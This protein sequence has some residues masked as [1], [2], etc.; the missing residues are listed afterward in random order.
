MAAIKTKDGAEFI[1]RADLNSLGE[2][3][4]IYG[5]VSAASVKLSAVAELLRIAAVLI[6]E[7]YYYINSPERITPASLG[8][9]LDG[10]DIEQLTTAVLD[11]ITEGVGEVKKK[12][13]TAKQPKKR[14]LFR[15]RG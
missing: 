6:N 2:I 9:R 14:E 13:G 7:H 15:S 10:S 5:T 1:L 12:T 8:A 4:R 3:Q 11:A